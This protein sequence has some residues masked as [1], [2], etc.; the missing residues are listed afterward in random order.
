[1]NANT[2]IVHTYKMLWPILDLLYCKML[3][4]ELLC[5]GAKFTYEGI[6]G[7]YNPESVASHPMFVVYPNTKEDKI[8]IRLFLYNHRLIDNKK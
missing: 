4:S 2:N 6:L 1:M 5:I 3:A 7:Y 8:L